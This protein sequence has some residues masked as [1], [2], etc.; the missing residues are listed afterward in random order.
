MRIFLHFVAIFLINIQ[1]TF[2]DDNVE[3][4]KKLLSEG[5]IT[6]EE[7]KKASSKSSNSTEISNDRIKIKK[8]TT[9]KNVKFVKYEFYIDNYR[10]HTLGPGAIRADNLL[11]GETDVKIGGNFKS[12][13]T[14]EGKKYF[15]LSLDKENLSAKLN[16]KGRML[17]NWSGKYVAH[18]SATFYQM[19]VLGYMPFHFYI[20]LKGKNPISLNIDKFNRKIEKAVNR[21]KE[22]MAIKFDISIED[23]DKI[24]ERKNKSINNEIENI[25]SDEKQKIIEEL[26]NKYAGKE[27]TDAIREE[28]EKTI[29]EEMANALI[30]EI[31]N[32][33]GQAIDEAVETELAAAINE[34]ITYAVQMGVS[35]AAAEAA[36]AAMLW[37]YAHGG[38]DE[39]A[40]DA[41]RA[42]AGDAC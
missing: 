41:C 25:I 15:D 12:K 39:E 17:I 29:G 7:F 36:I 8:S 32:A 37:V 22:E 28:I 6:E 27:I 26:T 9:S 42:Y 34:A 21:V 18:H 4:L 10:I 23:I 11:T 5:L 3:T 35:E 14:N 24:L 1:A 19:Q 13:F 38:S 33:T 2:S 31:E 30:S 20:M 40:L 16:Y